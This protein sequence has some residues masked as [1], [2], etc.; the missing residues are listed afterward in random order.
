MTSNDDHRDVDLAALNDLPVWDVNARRAQSLGA[1]CRAVLAAQT[2]ANAAAANADAARWA[3]A[4]GVTL[5]AVWCAIYVIAIVRRGAE[6]W[7]L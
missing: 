2:R 6:V 4:T 3:R 5:L 7:G 1:C